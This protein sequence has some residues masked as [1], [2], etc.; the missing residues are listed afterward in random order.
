MGGIQDNGRI[1]G[2]QV[3]G[4]AHAVG[5]RHRVG[6]VAVGRPLQEAGIHTGGIQAIEKLALVKNGVGIVGIDLNDAAVGAD[7][8]VVVGIVSAG[9]MVGVHAHAVGAQGEVGP[10]RA[11]AG[12]L[13]K[14]RLAAGIDGVGIGRIDD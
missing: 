8:Q 1:E 6:Q 3:G 2:S 11:G 5:H 7:E 12:A 14:N 9:L 13:G 10:G 4:R